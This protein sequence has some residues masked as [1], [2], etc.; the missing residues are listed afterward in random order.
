MEANKNHSIYR[1]ENIV[2]IMSN[3]FHECLEISLP[4]FKLNYTTE[5]K[6][7]GEKIMD[8]HGVIGVLDLINA[9]FLVVITEVELSFLLF[10]REI[11]KIKNVEFMLLAID[12]QNG[13]II[14]DYYNQGPNKE[15][16]EENKNIC[17]ELKKFF[18]DGFYFSNKYDLANSFSSHNQIVISKNSESNNV[19][20]DYDQI[21]E[22][23]R[24]FLA[25]FKLINRLIMPDEKNN[26]RV[27]ASN[28][29]YGNIET[30]SFD[31]KG[32]GEEIE[33]I[34]IIVI[35]RR[36]LMNFGFSNF[37]KGLTKKGLNSNLVETEVI[38]IYNNSEIYSHVYISSYLPIFFR[39]NSTYTQNN[40]I[41]GFHNY[42]QSLI[43]EYNL[44]VM[45]GISEGENHKKYFQILTN[46]ILTDTFQKEQK[47]KY[48]YINSQ[49]KSVKNILKE[50]MDNGSNILEILGFS[51]NNNSLKYKNDFSQIGSIYLFGLNE[52][53]IHNNQFYLTYKILS[54]IYKNISKSSKKITKEEEFIEGLK[55]LFKKRKE[56]LI[57]QYTPNI[58]INSIEKKQRMREIVFGKI[59]KD[60]K[61]DFRNLRE[62]FSQR[63]EIKIFIGSWNVA[64][65][66]LIKYPEIN[67]DSWLLPKDQTIIPT[68]YIIGLQEV[69]ELN[70]GN[71][72]LNLEDR[73]KILVDWAVKIENSI[74]KIGNY[75]KLIAMNLVG[76]NL[77]CYVLEKNFDNINNLTKKYVKT[78]FGGAGNKGS[79]CINFNY[80]S[81]SISIACSHLAAGEKKN[82]QRLKEINDVLAQNISSFI[83]PD[84]LNIL[85]EESDINPENKSDI[86]TNNEINDNNNNLNSSSNSGTF[87]DSDIWFLFGDLNFRIDM[88]Y[89]EFSEFIKNGQDWKKLLEYDQFNKN[90]E[91]SIEFME[92]IKEDPIIHQPSYKYIIFS[93]QYDYDSKDKNEEE[94]NNV[95]LSGK[96]RNPSWCDRIF[97]KKNCFETKDERKVIQSLGCYNCI[98]D[99][100]F[101]T[102]DHRPIF[103]IFDIIV[104]KD[105]EEKKKR[106]E[107]EVNFNNK[108]NIKSS[109]FQ[110][111]DFA[112]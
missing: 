90:Q 6:D 20:I 111:K 78:G 57:S 37:K 73:E 100:N 54:H 64:S 36:N 18:S 25:N 102:S 104:F 65:T 23:N 41:K 71:I 17:E 56:Q 31:K 60:L 94:G 39:N 40:I 110:K 86:E 52:E 99:K 108:L 91:A 42:F 33:K 29:I 96:K 24:N 68:I 107:K 45:M 7:F 106:L 70:A 76:I 69:V 98:F 105:D 88:E 85:I 87:K 44:L 15:E 67:L 4:T 19:V 72:M 35:S 11:Y 101:Q 32:E 50:S 103:N 109:Y 48:F 51:H 81:S 83:K 28:C 14:N 80:N 89:E 75:K 92:I 26:L 9:S 93:D 13:E 53:L 5:K 82:K 61:Q 1:K 22:G 55:Q 8:C 74:Q 63:S 58:D 77:Y 27:F 59:F 46:F 47:L 2:T 112:Y 38:M 49:G 34:Q 21:A 62:D 84:E 16:S 95:N 30:F 79:C 10:K 3:R 43:D 97:Y 12:S 66:S